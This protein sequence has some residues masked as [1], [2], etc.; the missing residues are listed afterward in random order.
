MPP[1]QYL[2]VYVLVALGYASLFW[3]GPATFALPVLVFGLIPVAEH[4][5]PGT[6]RNFTPD[7]EKKRLGNPW[8]DAL[9][10]L[11]IPSLYG[12]VALLLWRVETGAMTGLSLLGGVASVGLL[13]GAIGINVGHELGHRPGVLH[14]R[15]SKALLFTALYMHFF[16]EHNRGHHMRVA[17]D[18]DPASARRGDWVYGHWV[19]SIIGGL[20]SAWSLEATRLERRGGSRW[21]LRNE[22]LRGLLLEGAAVVAVAALLSPLAAAVWVT[23][24]LLGILTLETVN[25]VEHYGLRREA[26]ENGRFERVRPHHSWN[27]NHTLGRILLFDLSRHSDH[28]ANPRRPFPVLRHFDDAPQLPTGYPGMMVLSLFPPLFT[29]VME[30]ELSRAEREYFDREVPAAA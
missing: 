19:R 22:V 2:A 7:E 28:H 8:F 24:A 26:K 3:Q 6:R 5:L 4:F 9:L 16:V 25:Y 13:I 21:S 29:T 20:R 12:V 15:A 10:F 1:I 14:Q 30:R 17:T 11:A 23:C 18:E 27:S